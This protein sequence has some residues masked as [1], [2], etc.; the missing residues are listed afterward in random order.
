MNL[1]VIK[2]KEAEEEMK[3]MSLLLAAMTK[4]IQFYIISY[5]KKPDLIRY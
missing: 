2:P 1:S 5:F 3:E 4:E